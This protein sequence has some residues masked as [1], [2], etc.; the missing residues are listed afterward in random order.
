MGCLIFLC[1][2]SQKSPMISGSFAEGDLQL[3]TS[4]AS[5]HPC[6]VL[7]WS[8]LNTKIDACVY[9]YNYTK[10]TCIEMLV[11]ACMQ[12]YSYVRVCCSL[13]VALV[14][15]HVFMGMHDAKCVVALMSVCVCVSM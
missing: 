11:L 2:S 9:I 4:S 12:M 8:M 3:E 13:C 1:H 10:H 15:H 6:N 5:S 14:L 7:L